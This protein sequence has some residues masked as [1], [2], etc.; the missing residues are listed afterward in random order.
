[1][2]K[3]FDDIFEREY[4]IFEDKCF[5]I[6]KYFFVPLYFLGRVF[7]LFL[8]VFAVLYLWIVMDDEIGIFKITIFICYNIL[9]FIWALSLINLLSEHQ[10]LSFILPSSEHLRAS[11]SVEE[12]EEKR[13]EIV[14]YYYSVLSI[15]VAIKCCTALF[16]KDITNIIMQ[17]YEDPGQIHNQTTN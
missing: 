7:N 15:Y 13:K 10:Y 5:P 11:Y 6:S 2:K 12:N 3:Y 4:T 14:S 16:G 17:Y 1:M 8:F 9:L